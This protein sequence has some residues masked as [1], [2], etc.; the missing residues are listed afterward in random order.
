MEKPVKE[1]INHLIHAIFER[2][3]VK[4]SITTLKKNKYFIPV[5][6]M[7][8]CLSISVGITATLKSLMGKKEVEASIAANSAETAFYNK[9]YDIAVAEYTKMQESEKDW[10]IWNMKIAEIYSVK[11]EFA[12]SNELIEKVYEARNKLVDTK[13]DKDKEKD[14]NLEAKDKELMNLI[15]FTTLM[16]GEY[17]K[18]LEYGEV[19]LRKYPTDKN[20]LRTMTTI[21]L[22][23][24]KKDKAKEIVDI[25]QIDNESASDLAVIA[26]MNMLV[27]DF[28]EGFALLKDAWYKDKN[29]VKVFDV[30]AQ[31]TDYNKTDIVDRISKFEGKEPNELVYKMWM[32]KIYSMS[33][34]SAEKADELIE[35][36]DDEDVGN[37]N[38]MLI[39]ANMYQNM[40]EIEKAKDVLD[41]V[42]KDDP[43]SFIGYHAAAWQ[44]YNNQKYAEAFKDCVKSIVMNKDYPDNYGFLI[45]EILTKQNKSEE[46]EPYFRTAL[47]K[48]PFNYNI[49][50]KIAEYYGNTIKNTSR[51]L[52]YYDLAAR[53]KPNDPEIYYNMALI[54]LNNQKPDDAIELLKKSTVINDKDPKYHRA[55][56]TVY[57]NKDKNDEALK[58]IRKAYSI[59]KNDIL[60]LNNAGCYYISVDGDIDR[61]MVN[62]KAAYDGMTKETSTEDREI[63]TENYNRVKELSKAYNKRNGATLK[64][65]DLKL[66]Y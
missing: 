56:G 4:K 27:D 53:I 1:Y 34:D 62:L 19:F 40:G 35:K 45:P 5:I 66:F 47:Y 60:T 3:Q 21:Y 7:I 8:L 30:I 11:G 50:I 14:E 48:E 59:D 64:V 20:L 49:M 25:Y 17:K 51:A 55:L 57:L 2:E 38:L 37:V 12:K 52:Y 26:R 32:A 33:K 41:E 15:V 63:I 9:K 65:P 23:N 31:I 61:G 16:N 36:L 6:T 46:A 18:S 58:E 44:A 39:K 24:G 29:E 28:D 42:I 22:V 54:N 10:P 43:K 13:K